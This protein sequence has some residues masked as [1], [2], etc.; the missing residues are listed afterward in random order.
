MKIERTECENMLKNLIKEKEKENI[1]L[2]TF[3]TLI[4]FSFTKLV[5]IKSKCMSRHSDQQF[6]NK[7]SI[8][9]EG[10]LE[11]FPLITLKTVNL[12]EYET[13]SYCD[14]QIRVL[15]QIIAY[16]IYILL[17]IDWKSIY[18]LNKKMGNRNQVVPKSGMKMPDFI[19]EINISLNEFINPH[20]RTFRTERSSKETILA[21]LLQRNEEEMLGQ[22]T[23]RSLI[24]LIL[25]EPILKMDLP[26]EAFHK[27]QSFTQ[28]N[29]YI[30]EQILQNYT[31]LELATFQN[32]L[33]FTHELMSNKQFLR[34]LVHSKTCSKMLIEILRSKHFKEKCTKDLLSKI[35]QKYVIDI[36]HEDNKSIS[37]LHTITSALSKRQSVLLLNELFTKCIEENSIKAQNNTIF[38]KSS[39]QTLLILQTHMHFPYVVEDL[40]IVNPSIFKSNT[41]L[42]VVAK[43][44]II[45][46]QLNILYLDCPSIPLFD[47]KLDRISNFDMNFKGDYQ[48]E[49]G[50]VRSLL[51]ILFSLVKYD[52]GSQ[53]KSIVILKFVLFNLD[54]DYVKL[55]KIAGVKWKERGKYGFRREVA[56]K[57][58]DRVSLIDWDCAKKRKFNKCEKECYNLM[59]MEAPLLYKYDSVENYLKFLSH[60]ETICNQPLFYKIMVLTE[61]MHLCILNLLEVEGYNEIHDILNCEITLK[62]YTKEE[63]SFSQKFQELGKLIKLLCLF[64]EEKNYT[65]S[66]KGNIQILKRI[67]EITEI[68][69]TKFYSNQLAETNLDLKKIYSS[70]QHGNWQKGELVF[71]LFFLMKN[72]TL[73]K[74]MIRFSKCTRVRWD[75]MLLDQIVSRKRLINLFKNSA[76]SISGS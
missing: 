42:I 1:I 67:E 68:I 15:D 18:S 74:K 8:S 37:L 72:I 10:G 32:F 7:E 6:Q 56:V 75:L 65:Q 12:K 69:K 73:R 25:S 38:N 27:Q 24:S 62:V 43:L 3:L 23:F 39:Q 4:H 45:L 11:I 46:A 29:F 71:P 26:F 5:E 50:V 34:N 44:V 70:I 30:F 61:L 31:I 53:I 41:F 9:S 17:T 36:V 55:E 54:E 59:C 49:G 76:S 40:C 16:S 19:A 66:E 51:R 13:E 14:E 20:S 63:K 21:F 64:G 47:Y 22:F 2:D 60:K 57:E 52:S 28:D 33:R 35:L 48:R 58:K